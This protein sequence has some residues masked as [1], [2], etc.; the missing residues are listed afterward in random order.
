MFRQANMLILKTTRGCNLNCSYCY[1][2]NKEKYKEERMDFDLYKKVINRIVADKK[3]S[4]NGGKFTLVYHGGEPLLNS[5]LELSKMFKYAQTQFV[6]NNIE[7]A[8]GMQTNLT[9]MT[10]EYADILRHYSVSVGASFDGINKGNEGRTKVINQGAFEEKFKIMTDHGVQFGFL[11]VVSES[12][13]DYVMESVEYLQEKYKI[14]GIKINYAEDVNGVGG[15]VSGKEFFEKAWKPFI[16]KYISGEKIIENN[17]EEIISQ[18][19]LNSI[20]Y[21]D[22]WKKSNCGLK[23][24]GGGVNIIEM[25]PDGGVYLCGRYSEEYPEAYVMHANDSDFLSLKQIKKYY[26]FI[27]E[28][29]KHL[30]SLGCDTCP[31]DYIC[32]HG[33]MAFHFSKFGEFGIRKDLVCEIFKPLQNY[34]DMN[35]FKIFKTYYNL[36][37]D[38]EDKIVLNLPFKFNGVKINTDLLRRISDELGVI[39]NIADNDPNK[40]I[41]SKR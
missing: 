14:K 33:C 5:P 39:I 22:D 30:I 9:L 7:Y 1:V 23:I 4:N 41:I 12:N 28:K 26:D 6:K 18:Y 19:V 36:N 17:L 13:I 29:H 35:A 20:S 16:D 15:E 10:E 31:A 21:V 32:D 3:I 38:K 27:K 40:I 8:F 11:M 25:N 24:C 2:R 37:K 34:L